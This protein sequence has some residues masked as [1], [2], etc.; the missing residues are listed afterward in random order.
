MHQ[1]TMH[2]L[3]I[4]SMPLVHGCLAIQLLRGTINLNLNLNTGADSSVMVLPRG[5]AQKL[6]T[7]HT[8]NQL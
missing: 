6:N 7:D 2:I 5:T 4:D 1:A 3:W 8:L